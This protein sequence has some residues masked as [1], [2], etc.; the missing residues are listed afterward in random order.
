MFLDMTMRS[1]L[2]MVFLGVP[3][4]ST[5]C[6]I[7]AS[8]DD[9]YR[10]CKIFANATIGSTYQD[11]WM[12]TD[13]VNICNWGLS[14]SYIECGTVSDTSIEE[15][16]LIK[17]DV[18]F[19]S[20]SLNL[21]PP[22]QYPWPEFIEYINLANSYYVDGF[23]SNFSNLPDT[24]Y[25]LNF[26]NMYNL[27]GVI[28]WDTLPRELE[29]FYLYFTDLHADYSNLTQMPQ[30]LYGFSAYNTESTSDTFDWL[31]LPRD[32]GWIDIDEV[33]FSGVI[34]FTSLPDDLTFI[35][36]GYC[37]FDY[38]DV[39]DP[40]SVSNNRLGVCVCVFFFVFS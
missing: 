35:D 36:V 2:C 27:G 8:N 11:S 37:D 14:T 32:L 6:S 31:H 23:W 13:E 29:Y 20:G 17:I 5:D 18:E 22:D 7:Y 34:N 30:T 38:L 4:L 9:T 19:D 12:R 40:D 15:P 39:G 26:G 33:K 28:Q 24:V 10:I 16:R 21:N 25:Y 3:T 1:I